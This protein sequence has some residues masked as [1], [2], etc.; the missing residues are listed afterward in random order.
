[1]DQDG[2]VHISDKPGLGEDINFDFINANLV[3]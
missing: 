1:M 2:F 3:G